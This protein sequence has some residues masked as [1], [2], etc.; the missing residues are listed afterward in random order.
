MKV[1][2]FGDTYG[3]LYKTF[4]EGNFLQNLSEISKTQNTRVGMYVGTLN[5]FSV[6]RINVEN[7]TLDSA[8]GKNPKN[9]VFSNQ[10]L[11]DSYVYMM[12]G[13]NETILVSPS[14]CT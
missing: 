5:G 7:T 13:G 6:H 11:I 14:P 9:N 12:S 2:I 8:F 10:Q 4:S 1:E 3:H